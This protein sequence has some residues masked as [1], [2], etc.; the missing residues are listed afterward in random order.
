MKTL[1][2]ESE[3]P[4]FT[5]RVARGLL[6]VFGDTTTGEPRGP[7][8]AHVAA[9]EA[10]QCYFSACDELD[11]A[12]KRDAAASWHEAPANLEQNILRAINLAKDAPAERKPSG[13]W[14]TLASVATCA[15]VAVL[16][17]QSGTSVPSNPVALSPVVAASPTNDP[18]VIALARDLVA[19]V[20]TDVFDEMQPKAQALLQRDPLQE[21]VAAAKADAL[22]AVQFLAR[23]FLP[24]AGG[25]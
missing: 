5:C 20:P 7:G 9:C 4:R 16:V 13:A 11:L 18:S 1:T 2:H 17:S 12:L 22:K 3:T 25:E 24:V 21:E 10:C 19:A 15:V 6:A 8:A 14:L 23:N